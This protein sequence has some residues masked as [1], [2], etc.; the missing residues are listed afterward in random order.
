VL[1][2]T[3][4]VCYG[5]VSATLARIA[6]SRGDIDEA[7]TWYERALAALVP[8]G[9]P[10]LQ[11]RLERELVGLGVPAG[12]VPV[13]E[14]VPADAARFEREG[15]TWLLAFAGRSTRLRDAKGLR[16]LAVLLARPDG[17]VH[18]LDLVA[19]SE[20]HAR[21][22]SAADG[23]VGPALDARARG[24][25]EARIRDLTELIED[26]DAANDIGRAARLDDERAQLLRELAAA[27]GLSGRARS[28]SSDA[29]RARKAV[30]MRIRDTI[31]RID[32]ELPAL[33][34]HLRNSVR[35]GIFCSYRPEQPLE[36]RL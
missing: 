32:R 17:E 4:A 11:A 9:A 10:L 25:Y 21:S 19:A 3:A 35:T 5:P 23:D 33:G 28:Q 27:L 7:R 1:D 2:G 16:D 15:D 29:E 30:T 26:A 36:W 24:E 14:V 31:G 20:G 12:R 8:A 13:V 18:A 22:D 6:Q 34:S